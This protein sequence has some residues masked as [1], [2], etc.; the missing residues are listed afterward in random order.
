M[1]FVSVALPSCGVDNGASKKEISKQESPAVVRKKESEKEDIV[2]SASSF[3]ASVQAGLVEVEP[4]AD[5]EKYKVPVKNEK[6]QESALELT[7]IKDL[8]ANGETSQNIEKALKMA[9]ATTKATPEYAPV[10]NTAGVLYSARKREREAE[11]AYLRAIA[12]DHRY[13]TAVLNLGIHYAELGRF[14]DANRVFDYVVKLSPENVRCWVIKGRLLTEMAKPKEA[15]VCYNKALALDPKNAEAWY[16]RGYL[17]HCVQ[18]FT[19][20]EKDYYTALKYDPRHRQTF[21]HLAVCQR[22]QNR[23]EDAEK[24]LLMA[25]RAYPKE[26]TTWTELGYLMRVKGNDKKALEYFFKAT[27]ANPSEPVGL[28]EEG[29][30]YRDKGDFKKADVAFLKARK[31]APDWYRPWYLLG[32][33]ALDQYKF[34]ESLRYLHA[35]ARCDSENDSIQNTLGCALAYSHH[36]EESEKAFRKA[37]ELNP[38]YTLAWCNLAETL[39]EMGKY[40]ESK[41]CAIKALRLNARNPSVLVL[42][43]LSAVHENRNVDAC[44]LLEKAIRID[45]ENSSAWLNLGVVKIAQKDLTEA[46]K[47]LRKATELKPEDVTAWSNLAQ[48]LHIKGDKQGEAQ[49]LKMAVKSKQGN[50]PEELYRM[51]YSLESLG[52][53][54]D[55]S[56]ARKSG[57]DMD[58]AE[59]DVLMNVPYYMDKF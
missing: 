36:V 19:E 50:R 34:E 14:D 58:P 54:K 1:L 13:F 10:W 31:I 4:L 26:P 17:Y 35:A 44:K 55:A 46:E 43:A 16:R 6:E 29:I 27:A 33:S 39:R 52:H 23:L 11:L 53:K 37:V 56:I 7:K 48:I 49:A 21:R 42:L 38:R 45:P 57:L 32:Q 47:C 3:L 18:R 12:L 5:A 28:V 22:K 15:F 8:T 40:E 41:E 30:L 25:T 51:A 20:A 59:A 24:T 2:E 9:I